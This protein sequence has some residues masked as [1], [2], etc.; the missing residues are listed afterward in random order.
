[1]T[2]SETNDLE[3]SVYVSSGGVL[4]AL[5]LITKLKQHD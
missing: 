2:G 5:D 1:M 4:K 3:L